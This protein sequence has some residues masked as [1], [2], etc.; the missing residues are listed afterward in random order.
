[1][2]STFGECSGNVLSTP[3]PNDCLRTVNVSREPAPWRLMT[4]PSK[5]W[6][7]ERAP[8][9]TRKW[10]RTLSPALNRGRPLRS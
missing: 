5:T 2:R 9:I 1:M 10:T 8:S 3:T 7:R 4:M 6:S